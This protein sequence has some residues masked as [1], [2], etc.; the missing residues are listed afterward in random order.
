VSTSLVTGASG[1]VGSAVTRALLAAGHRVRVLLRPGSDRRNVHGLSVEVAIGDLAEPAT[2]RAALKGCDALF[3]VAADYRLWARR[4][5]E[6]YTHNVDGTVAL[7]QAARTAGLARIVYTSSV[8]T[9]GIR[10]DRRPAD[11]DT[12]VAMANM[13][14]HYKRSKFLAEGAVRRL[15][16]EHGLPAVI[17]NPSTPVGPRDI[18]P[19]PTGR[20]ILDATCGRM[21]AYV[22]TGLNIVHVDDVAQGHLQ[23]FE[24]G[25]VGERYIL[26]GE[27]LTLREILA[28]IAALTGRPAPRLRLPHAAVLPIA[29]L[30]E[31]W[32]RL[33]G[34]REPRVTADG[35]RMSRK[36]MFF[37]SDKARR[38]LGYSPRPADEALRD[39]IRWFLDNDYCG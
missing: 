38:E 10:P 17:V 29:Y 19:T 9:L 16:R 4:P 23:A 28:R 21:P 32:A 30:S 13:I 7:M 3:H 11:E 14:G 20:M 1:F 24:R 33:T 8:A 12:P 6:L 37:S 27:D 26:G 22:D 36:H 31:A 18:K 35:V 39:A 5:Q 34:S 2:L 25:T 15:V